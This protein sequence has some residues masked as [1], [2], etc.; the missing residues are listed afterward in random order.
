MLR[1]GILI[2]CGHYAMAVPAAGTS[3]VGL[4]LISAGTG[5]L[6]PDV[7]TMVGKLHRTDDDRPDTGFA[8]YYTAINIGAFAG[9]LVTGR[10]GDRRG[11]HRGFSAAATGTTFGLAQY[12]LGRRHLAKRRHAAEYALAPPAMR[13]GIRLVVAGVVVVGVVVGVLVAGATATTFVTTGR[14]TTDRFIDLLTL[15]PVIAPVVYSAVMSASRRGTSEERGRSLGGL[16]FLLTAPPT[17]GHGSDDHLKS[18]WWAVG[19]HP[20]LGLGDVLPETSGMS[21]TTK[22]APV[23]LSSRTMS[24]WFLSLAPA[25]GIQAQTVKLYDDVSRSVRFGVNG[26]TAVAAGLR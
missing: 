9:P 16:P 19:S 3:W 12:V 22:P 7:A 25:N 26:A 18:A 8:P 10:L 4:G 5:L 15:V 13:R 17:D 11:W 20:L 1:G 2:A 14:L 24:L 23:T 21:A 6:K